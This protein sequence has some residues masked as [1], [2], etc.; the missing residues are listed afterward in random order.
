[1]TSLYIQTTEGGE[2]YPCTA[3]ITFGTQGHPVK[4]MKN[5]GHGSDHEA[6]IHNYPVNNAVG[7][8]GESVTVSVTWKV[9]YKSQEGK[10]TK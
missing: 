1:M 9:S 6:T 10:A 8:A 2:F 3:T 7:R 5:C 4:C